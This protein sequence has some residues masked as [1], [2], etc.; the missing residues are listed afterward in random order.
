MNQT[1][2]EPLRVA[3]AGLGAIGFPVAQAL[4][5]GIPGLAL[6]AVAVR[7]RPRARDKMTAFKT[8]PDL[9]APGDLAGHGDV[10]M[11][12]APA[13]VFREIAEPA[14]AAGRIFIPL[15]VGALLDHWDLVDRAEQTGAR[16]IVPSGALLGL[17]AVRAAAE[18]TIHDVT[19]VT[20]KPPRGL[21]TA[22]HVI[23]NG[24]DMDALKEPLQVFKGTAREAIKGF[25]ANVNVA[26]ALSL[27]GVGPDR[28]RI[29]I[30][31]DPTVERNTHR[32]RV[33]AD[34]TRFQMT[35]EGVPSQENPA[36]GLLTPLSAIACLRGLTQTLRVG[37]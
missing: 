11:E 14:I 23:A 37:T 31:A 18:G 29:E 32:I 12:C 26:V 27:A 30:W 24:W 15:S 22:P 34:S 35:I 20:R 8:Q 6:S 1:R 2:R 9:L 36:T 4:D 25:P 5:D 21:R 10:V 3:I 7:D 33:D 17:D 16:I 28:T 13:A 19:I